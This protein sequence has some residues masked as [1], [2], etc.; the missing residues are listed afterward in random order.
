MSQ[1]YDYFFINFA[2]PISSEQ[3]DRFAIEMAKTNAAY[4]ICRV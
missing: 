4:K 3:V 1:V 2:R